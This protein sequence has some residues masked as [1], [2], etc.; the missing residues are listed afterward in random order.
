MN[1]Q[2]KLYELKNQLTTLESVSLKI[3]SASETQEGREQILNIIES[4][5]IFAPSLSSFGRFRMAMETIYKKYSPTF[6]LPQFQAD[7]YALDR[8]YTEEHG[9]LLLRIN[10]TG[11]YNDIKFIGF[12]SFFNAYKK[13]AEK[14]SAESI[15]YFIRD[16]IQDMIKAAQKMLSLPIFDSNKLVFSSLMYYYYANYKMDPRPHLNHIMND[17]TGR[18]SD[19]FKR[20]VFEA[21][22]TNPLSVR[23][24]LP[25]LSNFAW[26]N[27]HGYYRWSQHDPSSFVRDMKSNKALNLRKVFTEMERRL[28]QGP[29]AT[30][31]EAQEEITFICTVGVSTQEPHYDSNKK[32][33][34]VGSYPIESCYDALQLGILSTCNDPLRY[35][36][37]KTYIGWIE[38]M[39]DTSLF[40]TYYRIF[41]CLEDDIVGT[42]EDNYNFLLEK[43]PDLREDR[44]HDDML[45][46][47]IEGL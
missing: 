38:Y 6:I 22:G 2:D 11:E 10:T 9:Y 25:V 30:E 23:G 17:C 28:S 36:S 14:H 20:M 33:P 3:I 40:G 42:L 1:I 34:G 15:L 29:E 41:D 43:L 35:I 45:E 19:D 31:Q 39:S 18:I 12:P 26:S 32:F 8:V 27:S 24:N 5:E 16:C 44:L 4:H 21:N 13:S 7:A 47:I 37:T 46:Y